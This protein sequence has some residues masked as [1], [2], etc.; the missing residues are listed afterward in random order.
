M[1]GVATLSEPGYSVKLRRS[2]LLLLGSLLL[3][4]LALDFAYVKF[5]HPM[6]GDDFLSMQLNVDVLQYAASVMLFSLHALTLRPLQYSVSNVFQL[7][8][9]I[10]IVAPLTS[11]YGLDAEKSIVPV[12]ATVASLLIIRA[13]TEVRVFRGG[14]P[15]I[16]AN[17]RKIVTGMAIVGVAYLIAWAFA[18]G[19]ISNFNLRPDLVYEFRD[20][21]SAQL[22]VGWLAYLNLWV[23]KILTIYLVVLCLEQK[24]YAGLVLL[25]LVQSFFSAVTNHKLVFFLPFLAIGFWYFLGKTKQLYPLPLAAALLVTASLIFFVVWDVELIAAMLIRRLDYVPSGLPFEWFDYFSNHPH[26]WWSDSVLSSFVRTEYTG[27]KIPFVVGDHLLFGV[28]LAAN[29]GLA[30]AGYAH[31]GRLGIALYSVILGAVLNLL[32]HLSATGVPLSIAV[33]LTIGPLR[34]A[35]A[36]ADLPTALVSHGVLVALLVVWLLR[37]KS[38]SRPA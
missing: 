24:N 36:D 37:T 19:A 2:Y 34:T 21:A 12:A 35:L 25:L 29:N 17:G 5:V 16:V 26:V 30:S 22:D 31:G 27:E 33:V 10:F 4:R 11:Q 15:V 6:Y 13:I 20:Q 7:M 9:A 14:N 28:E 8:A 3:L 23:Y 18:S 32:D 1:S 38:L